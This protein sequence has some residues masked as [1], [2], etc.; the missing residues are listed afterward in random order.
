MLDLGN[1][2]YAFA[3][4]CPGRAFGE[5]EDPPAARARLVESSLTAMHEL[6]PLMSGS[7][8]CRPARALQRRPPVS[9]SRCSDRARGA[10]RNVSRDAL[11][12]RSVEERPASSDRQPRDLRRNGAHREARDLGARLPLRRLREQAVLRRD[13]RTDRFS[14]RVSQRGRRS[15]APRSTSH[16]WRTRRRSVARP[17][18]QQV[19]AQASRRIRVR[20]GVSFE[21]VSA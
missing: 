5:D 6:A 14:E 16:L 3:L 11:S 18:D 17:N 12:V 20:A 15:Y 4:R 10:R 19:L 8:Q 13:A 1:A 2:V 9:P 21:G 7:P